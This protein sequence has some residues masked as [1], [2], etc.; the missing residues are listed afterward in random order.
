MLE[1]QQSGDAWIDH[2]GYIEL[3]DGAIPLYGMRLVGFLDEHGA[4][5]FNWTTDGATSRMAL[6]GALDTAKL[7]LQCEFLSATAD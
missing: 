6:V 5:S 3:P 2:Y 1:D 4:M 7:T